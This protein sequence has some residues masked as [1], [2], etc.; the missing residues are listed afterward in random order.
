MKEKKS[1]KGKDQALWQ[2]CGND[3]EIRHQDRHPF[4]YLAPC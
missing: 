4:Q 1:K 2:E 3:G